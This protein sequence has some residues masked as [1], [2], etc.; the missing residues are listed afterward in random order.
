MDWLVLQSDRRVTMIV[1][2]LVTALPP[3]LL[4]WVLSCLPSKHNE[5]LQLPW[6]IYYLCSLFFSGSLSNLLLQF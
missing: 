2:A 4:A 6:T 3:F 5:L 1:L